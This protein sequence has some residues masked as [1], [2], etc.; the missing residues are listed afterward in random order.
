[1]NIIVN[2][3]KTIYWHHS[4]LQK[5]VYWQIPEQIDELSMNS[6]LDSFFCSAFQDAYFSWFF[7]LWTDTKYPLHLSIVAC[8]VIGSLF[9][10]FS[11]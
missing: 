11:D 10:S 5:S 7:G 4:I 9:S 2:Y 6:L 3:R 8:F 1:M